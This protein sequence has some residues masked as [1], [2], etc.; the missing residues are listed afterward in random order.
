ML[1]KQKRPPYL[2]RLILSLLSEYQQ[3]YS[4]CG[5]LEE[6]YHEIVA[7]K[8]TL[9]ASLWFWYQT[10]LCLSKYTAAK[11]YWSFA[12]IKN[13][14][15]I[16]FRNIQRHKGYSSINIAGLAL[17][18]TAVI[19]ILLLVQFE[20]SFDKYHKN[21]DRI[22]RV[23]RGRQGSD[24]MSYLTQPPLALTLKA[25]FPE[26]E[27]ATRFY[28]AGKIHI[29]F[30]EKNFFEAGFYFTDPE[31]FDIFSFELM[32]GDPNKV[33]TDPYSVI[34]SEAVAKKYFGNKNPIGKIIS[35]KSEHDFKIT[36][37]M[38]DLPDNSIFAVNFLAPFK[39]TQI[40]D[41]FHNH[42]SWRYSSYRTYFLLNKESNIQDL[43]RK[44]P[45]L[46]TKHFDEKTAKQIR[47]DF[48]PLTKIHLQSE[49]VKVIYL[50]SSVAILILIIACI[51]YINLATACSTQR[52]KE[53]G[54]RKVIG[55]YRHQLIKQI[56]GES[57][58][59]SIIA[60]SL[61]IILVAL[62]L[63]SFNVFVER[64]LIFNPVEN[65]QFLSWLV[66][67]LLFVSFV[68]GGYPAFAISTFNPM[69]TFR[70]RIA[71]SKGSK[72]RNSLVVGQFLISITLIIATLIIKDQ[73]HFI[74]NKDVGF[75]K[76][77]ILV[78]DIRDKRLKSNLESIKS[79]LKR[80]LNI[81]TVTS[82]IDLPNESGA[83]T[84]SDWSGRQQD[85][86]QEIF[87]NFI[88][89]DYIDLYEIDIKQG[90]NFSKDFV[91]DTAGAFL[92]NE[93]AIKEIGWE[94]PVGKEF[95]HF[96][97]G[98]TGTVIGVVSDFHMLPLHQSIQP[99]CL[100]LNPARANRILS[101]KIKDENI[102]KTIAYV[103][104]TMAIFSP[105]YPFEYMFFDDVF[106]SS[107]KLDQKVE[108]I[109][110]LFAVLAIFI[111]CL[112]LLGL[113]SFI[114]IQRTKEIGVRK[115]VGASVSQIVNMLTKQIIK[116]VLIA[117]VIAWPISYFV[118]NKW[119]QTFA[120]KTD[121][122][123]VIFIIAAFAA[124]FISF[125]TVS[126]Q[127]IKAAIDNPVKS[128]RYE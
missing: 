56:L 19:L 87:I 18:L 84:R 14:I 103:Q 62:L 49:Q 3:N 51:N 83:A 105:N 23:M 53:I 70:N 77:Q 54:I 43:E 29:S 107:Y 68:A 99:I 38:K 101:I 4:I 104:K 46:I 6:M 17:G 102:P 120:Y 28:P 113:A 64:N 92:L 55:A 72:L 86:E 59:F 110:T 67:L 94:E 124:I 32:D 60:F 16:A 71:G 45:D 37:V 109:L 111:A 8:N 93:T 12:M 33:F 91:S 100:D 52:M 22:Y 25:E 89:Y 128:L 10:I 58:L 96:L 26:V 65:L 75:A 11:M 80:N 74:R 35:Y 36:G 108:S 66:V 112:G 123:F 116:W 44:I 34:I 41:S 90:R 115:V 57:I 40:M 13:Y 42:E 48:Q 27:S 85:K 76:D 15:K 50:L 39:T 9:F 127:S 20:I 30:E 106:D 125:F 1:K 97:G 98:R 82:S 21:A 61:A 121:I 79:E 69:T 114:T 47:F 95:K 2:C 73:M 122:N 5:D 78:I 88:D 24:R 117:T 31:T 118:M 63:P 7:D 126:Y 81:L 119:L